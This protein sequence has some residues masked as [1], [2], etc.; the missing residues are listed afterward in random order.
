MN[1]YA[2]GVPLLVWQLLF[3]GSLGAFVFSILR[4]KY[5]GVSVTGMLFLCA[6]PVVVKDIY[7][8][9]RPSAII[10]TQQAT[11]FLGPGR[12]YPATTSLAQTTKVTLL[13]KHGAWVLVSCDDD[14]GW[15]YSDDL[16]VCD[17]H[18]DV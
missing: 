4:R 5:T 3:L 14:K 9:L 15:V 16:S 8:Y 10:V 17:G 18:T 2:L 11:L 13:K 12:N 6:V 7:E 1:G